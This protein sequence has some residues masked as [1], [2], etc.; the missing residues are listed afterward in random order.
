MTIL[1]VRNLSVDYETEQ[2]TLR[3]LRDVSFTIEDNKI[4]GVVGESGCGKSTLISSIINLPANNAVLSSGEI[5]FQG[6]DIV[7]LSEDEMRDILG[8]GVSIIFQ[9]PMQTHNP[10]LTVGRQMMDIQYRDKTS[11][12]QKKEAAIDMLRV[13]GIPDPESRLSQYP[14]EFSGGMRQR[15]AIAMALMVKPSLLIADEPTTA[16]DATLEVQ[17]IEKLR[18]LQGKINCSILFISHHLGVIAE[19]C[20]EV[21]VMYAGEIVEYGDVR[22]VFHNARHPYTQAL[23]ACDPGRIKEKS[24]NLPT[25][26]GSIPNL[27]DLPSGCIFK[28][29]C[30]QRISVCDTSPA[31]HRVSEKQQA[32]CH[33]LTQGKN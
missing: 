30:T 22:D 18:E 15:I 6:K 9:D 1:D 5:I 33:L 14:H 11:K 20:D 13:V 28:H 21:I 2:G 31:M 32:K 7:R 8:V 17:I 25:I 23:F 24:K 3:A 4:V 19:L 16:L 29:R 12:E 26:K 10:V 27:I